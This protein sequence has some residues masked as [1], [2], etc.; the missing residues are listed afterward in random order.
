M[1]LARKTRQPTYLTVVNTA[2]VLMEIDSPTKNHLPPPSTNKTPTKITAATNGII[3]KMDSE[4]TDQNAIT[5]S[6]NA[7][8]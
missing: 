7:A 4:T 2:Q 1:I 3:L 5:I 8:E 6:V